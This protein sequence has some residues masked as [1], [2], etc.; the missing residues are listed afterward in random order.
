SMTVGGQPVK[1]T[2]PDAN[3][4]IFTFASPFGPGVR[5]FDNLPILPKHKLGAALAAGTLAQAW[6]PA[7]PPSELVGLGPF[8]LREYTAGQRLVFDRNPHYWRTAADGERL[9][10]VDR[11]ILEVVPEQNAEL[12]RLIAG[13]TDLTHSE[14]RPDDYVQA[15]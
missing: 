7:T 1:A 4:V 9:P 6:G 10:Y 15:R 8:V 2:A 12:L 3:T 5:I 13:E 14:L 11:L